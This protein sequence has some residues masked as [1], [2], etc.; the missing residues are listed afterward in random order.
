M[1]LHENWG[2]LRDPRAGGGVPAPDRGQP[3]PVGAAP[4]GR[5]GPVPAPPGRAGHRAQRRGGRARRAGR[6]P[7]C[8]PRSGNLPARQREA[9]VL[10]YYLDLSEAQTAEAMGMSQGAVKSHT[11]RALAALRRAWRCRYEARGRPARERS[12]AKRSRRGPTGSRSPPTRC[13][14]IRAR[15]APGAP[16]RPRLDHRPGLARH[17]GRRDRHG[18]G[19]RLSRLRSRSPPPSRRP[20]PL[21]RRPRPRRRPPSATPAATVRAPV[22]FAGTAQG[23]PVLYREYHQVPAGALATRIAGALSA[24]LGGAAADP[25]Y[26]SAWP[27]GR[28]RAAVTSPATR[29]GRPRRRRDRAGRPGRREGR[30]PAAHPHRHRGLGRPGWEPARACGSCRRRPPHRPRAGYRTGTL[31]RAPPARSWPRSG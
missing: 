17:R 9:L 5:G 14:S 3:G 21:R 1:A 13:A 18:R 22:Y 7:R 8:S 19:G 16:A 4:P 25:D 30:H 10:R 24:L 15:I 29:R 11:S 28:R 20:A 2:R 31:T 12:C 6:T 23:R 26:A 27:A